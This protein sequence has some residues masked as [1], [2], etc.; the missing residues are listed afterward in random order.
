LTWTACAILPGPP[1]AQGPQYARHI[2]FEHGQ[3]REMPPGELRTRQAAA[4][5]AYGRAW[6]ALGVPRDVA[7]IY[8]R[9]IL[10]DDVEEGGARN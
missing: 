5:E 9:A 2:R 4:R 10:G 1:A 6:A 8:A 3:V 7:A